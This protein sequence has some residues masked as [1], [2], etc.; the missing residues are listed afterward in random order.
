M[1]EVSPEMTFGV[2]SPAF[3]GCENNFALQEY[4]KYGCNYLLNN[5][6][7]LYEAGYTPLECRFCHHDRLGKGTECHRALENQWNTVR[8]QNIIKRWIKMVDF[9]YT[10][11]YYKLIKRK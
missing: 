6:C 2:L 9:P 7:E 5:R 10:D 3:K 8:G 11:Y 4:S 1:L